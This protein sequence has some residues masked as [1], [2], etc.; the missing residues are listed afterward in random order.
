MGF[1]REQ[2]IIE[3]DTFNGDKNQAIAALFAKSIIVPDNL[4]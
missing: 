1:K 4:K 2:V 3:L